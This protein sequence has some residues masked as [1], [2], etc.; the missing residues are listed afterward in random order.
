MW[1]SLNRRRI[2]CCPYHKNLLQICVQQGG[3]SEVQCDLRQNQMNSASNKDLIGLN[4]E[5]FIQDFPQLDNLVP[6]RPSNSEV[7]NSFKYEDRR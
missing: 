1:P 2:C 6:Y 7:K 4:F 5:D 3:N